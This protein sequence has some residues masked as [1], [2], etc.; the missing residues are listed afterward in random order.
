MMNIKNS[1]N[2]VYVFIVMEA[3]DATILPHTVLS[4][5]FGRA[6]TLLGMI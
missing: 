5:E 2:L 1:N 3:T 6:F 4:L